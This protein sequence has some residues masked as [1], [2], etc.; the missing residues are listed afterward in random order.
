VQAPGTFTMG[1]AVIGARAQAFKSLLFRVAA[2]DALTF[3]AAPLLLIACYLPVRRAADA[4][5]LAAR[6]HE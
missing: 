2:I 1:G 3:T 4:S 5:P 6:R